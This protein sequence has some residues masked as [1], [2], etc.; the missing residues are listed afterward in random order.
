MVAFSS[1]RFSA[2]VALAATVPCAFAAVGPVVNSMVLMHTN[3]VHAQIEQK[4]VVRI[5][6]LEALKD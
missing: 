1:A 5:V 3:D 4:Y 6:I 2:L